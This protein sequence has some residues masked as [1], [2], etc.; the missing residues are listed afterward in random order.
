[1]E[2]LSPRLRAVCDLHAAE[3]REASGRHEYDGRIQDLSPDGVRSGLARLE[4]A[5][6][7]GGPLDDPHDEA[8]LTAFENLVRVEFGELDAAPV[9]R[10]ADGPGSAAARAARH[11]GRAR[12]APRQAI[13]WGQRQAVRRT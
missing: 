5:R 6:A 8:H 2:D 4:Q 10:R 12:L 1:M 11:R 9:P 3:V 7:G 13:R